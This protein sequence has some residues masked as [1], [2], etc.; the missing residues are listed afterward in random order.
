LKALIL[1]TYFY[2]PLFF[3]F[4]RL[5]AVYDVDPVADA[6]TGLDFPLPYKRGLV[7]PF[8]VPPT[9]FTDDPFLLIYA[10][11]ADCFS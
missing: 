2:V 3:S 4:P 11:R 5:P 8:N 1:A 6:L 9:S 7:S 10:R